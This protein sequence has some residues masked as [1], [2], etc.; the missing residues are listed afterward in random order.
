MEKNKDS[1]NLTTEADEC[2][3]GAAGGILEVA[4]FF[5]KISFSLDLIEG[6]CAL[7]ECHI[8]YSWESL[9]KVMTSC[10]RCGFW[11]HQRNK[12]PPP[13]KAEKK[14]KTRA[15]LIFKAAESRMAPNVSGTIKTALPGM[16]REVKEH[17]QVVIQAKD[18][19]GQM[20]GLSGTT[21]VSITLSDVNDS[22]PRFANRKRFLKNKQTTNK[23]EKL[24]HKCQKS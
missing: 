14:K 21:T 20:G 18:M 23:P 10:I 17:Y 4:R 5:C 16:D 7:S 15:D 9:K 13:Q 8:K 1:T 11:F 22:P 19:A 12:L 6:Q 3:P 2:V 24:T